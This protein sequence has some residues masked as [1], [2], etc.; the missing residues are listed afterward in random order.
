MG[1]PALITYHSFG[2]RM[3]LNVCMCVRV[4]DRKLLVV[5][6]VSPLVTVK[7]NEAIILYYLPVNHLGTHCVMELYS[8]KQ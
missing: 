4:N 6:Y 5:V 2:P 7:C 1:D 8:L 3:S